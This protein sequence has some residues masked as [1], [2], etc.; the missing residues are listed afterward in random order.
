MAQDGHWLTGQTLSY[1]HLAY[2]FQIVSS[3]QYN[4]F[5]YFINALTVHKSFFMISYNIWQTRIVIRGLT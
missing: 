4:R 5:E 2:L 1:P 3:R